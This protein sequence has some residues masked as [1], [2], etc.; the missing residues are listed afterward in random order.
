MNKP[1]LIAWSV[2][3]IA[4]MLG[5]VFPNEEKNVNSTGVT[6]IKE[7]KEITVLCAPSFTE[8]ELSETKMRH[9]LV[10]DD[11][12][13]TYSVWLGDGEKPMLK[14]LNLKE[15]IVYKFVLEMHPEWA[16]A[17]IAQPGLVTPPGFLKRI[18]LNDQVVWE[19]KM[20]KELGVW[21]NNN[22]TGEKAKEK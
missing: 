20:F 7:N 15:N 10:L 19:D 16:G 12:E 17:A 2:M 13:E 1:K 18:V 21:G 9:Y 11:G 6:E 3:F 14:S 8:V 22:A 5:E 4:M